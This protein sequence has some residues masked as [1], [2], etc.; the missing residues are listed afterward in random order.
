[1]EQRREKKDRTKSRSEIARPFTELRGRDTKDLYLQSFLV[2]C[3]LL[4]A[5]LDKAAASRNT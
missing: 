4:T 1:M 5:A 2:V 3:G